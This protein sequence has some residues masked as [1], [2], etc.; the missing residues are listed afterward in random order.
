[1]AYQDEVQAAAQDLIR[2]D[3]ANWDLARRTY[4]NTREDRWDTSRVEMEQW[5]ADVRQAS[6][7]RFSTFTGKHYRRMWREYQGVNTHPDRPSW[8]EAVAELHP[9]QTYDAV[10]ERLAGAEIRHGTIESK[11]KLFTELA[12]DPSIQTAAETHG[13]VRQALAGLS[14]HVQSVQAARIQQTI[15]ADPI[16]QGIDEKSALLDLDD[17]LRRFAR[18][19]PPILARLSTIPAAERDPM[20]NLYFL[21]D[22]LAEVHQAVREIEQ[23]VLGSQSDA[24]ARVRVLQG[25]RDG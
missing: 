8:A 17:T 24:D 13:P 16:R 11:A 4:E 3:D 9:D 23:F 1:M 12:T 14:A 25:G 6:G 19:V 21:R 7:R 15:D 10:R 22:A 18:S 2:G 5:C 20:A